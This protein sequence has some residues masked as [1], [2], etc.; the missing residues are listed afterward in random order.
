MAS[1]NKVIIVGNLGR[2]PEVRYMPDGAALTNVSIATTYRWKEKA[3]GDQKEETEWHRV[4]FRGRLAEIAGEY[5][6][7]GS[8]VYVEGR[9]RTRKWQDK[10]GQERFTTEIVA[11]QMQLL[12]GRGEGGGGGGGQDADWSSGSS[13]SSGGAPSA[14]NPASQAARKPAADMGEMEDDIPF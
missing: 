2:D 12:G 11:D 1:V 3:T 13:G 8:P 4:A 5:L 6:K 14:R 7:K 10:E 9:L